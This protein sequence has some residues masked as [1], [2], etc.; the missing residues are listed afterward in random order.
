MMGLRTDLELPMI[1]SSQP[2]KLSGRDADARS[3]P[4]PSDLSGAQFGGEM[5]K[6]MPVAARL[7]KVEQE[8]VPRLAMVLRELDA[9]ACMFIAGSTKQSDAHPSPI[10]DLDVIIIAPN[11]MESDR[12]FAFLGQAR[13]EVA[14]FFQVSGVCP[15][16][17]TRNDLKISNKR[18]TVAALDGNAH[19][20][21]AFVHLLLYRGYEECHAD[22]AHRFDS[23]AKDAVCVLRPDLPEKPLHDLSWQELE[24]HRNLL[25][26]PGTEEL[27]LQP[28]DSISRHANMRALSA[29]L[30][31][32]V[33]DFEI[34]SGGNVSLDDFKQYYQDVKQVVRYLAPEFAELSCALESLKAVMPG[35]KVQFETA[36][37][38]AG[39]YSKDTR[40]K[41]VMLDCAKSLLAYIDQQV[42]PLAMPASRNTFNPQQTARC[43]NEQDRWEQIAL[44]SNG[45]TQS[46]L[47]RLLESQSAYVR[48]RAVEHLS[49]DGRT[50]A[51]TPICKAL[52]DSDL[53]VR[54]W[55]AH[56]LSR[57]GGDAAEAQTG[58]KD[59]L[60][61]RSIAARYW[62]ASALVALGELM[63]VRQAIVD[64]IFSPLDGG[65]SAFRMILDSS[66]HSQSAAYQLAKFVW[67]RWP[68]KIS[69]EDI[70]RCLASVK[71]K[72]GIS[73]VEMIKAIKLL[74]RPSHPIFVKALVDSGPGCV[75]AILKAFESCDGPTARALSDVLNEMGD[76][77][78]VSEAILSALHTVA[79][80]NIPYLIVAFCGH[81]KAA[82]EN[83]SELVEWFVA[84]HRPDIRRGI[85]EVLCKLGS[86]AYLAMPAAMECALKDPDR[87]S[88]LLAI[89]FVKALRKCPKPHVPK[90]YDAQLLDLGCDR[91][92]PKELRVE[93]ISD[94]DRL[95]IEPRLLLSTL[96]SAVEDPD[97]DV[98]AVVLSMLE[99]IGE[100]GSNIDEILDRALRRPEEE[101]RFKAIKL[102]NSFGGWDLKQQLFS[103]A[104][105]DDSPLVRICA[106]VA[107]ICNDDG[108]ASKP[109]EVV[110]NILRNH[111]PHSSPV[112]VA[113][114][115][116]IDSPPLYE[117]LLPNLKDMLKEQDVE[118]KVVALQALERL[119]DY[120]ESAYDEICN[121]E[122]HPD[123]N[124]R[125]AA[126][127][128]KK[129]ISPPED[130]GTFP[131]EAYEGT[132]DC[133]DDDGPR[134]A[135]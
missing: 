85:L 15:I 35:L 122:C 102:A 10:S 47:L 37:R 81:K 90:S 130:F 11:F 33:A 45:P 132:Q 3:I 80:K 22:L 115:G 125:S 59:L 128:A 126:A 49:D 99:R 27:R 38:A 78:G 39:G 69:K 135:R 2:D 87:E 127:D 86:D 53:G 116:I 26:T 4:H 67:Q 9:T 29:K 118:R 98:A 79:P 58:L 60:K 31:A 108:A 107:A 55:A 88:R 40:P 7:L 92:Q 100:S 113:L 101:S 46:E 76:Q 44:D 120:A 57:F 114:Q 104:I 94:L 48:R 30:V 21:E 16:V 32:A 51:I 83:I 68:D 36:Q 105:H 56:A 134:E 5:A 82:R 103:K 25:H 129:R 8:F 73:P 52:Q 96:R 84:E 131:S 24:L 43:V 6:I 71:R 75:S 13:Q 109:L 91:T 133:D 41:K 119:G 111:P 66:F 72:V 112:D 12:F 95:E 63:A 61:D 18:R 17:F 20:P 70:D 19:Y 42:D 64:K 106:A 77:K 110:W 65:R 54:C 50:S 34:Y 74:P 97:R 93:V 124:V 123:H 23:I 62:A 121:L 1:N 14:N 117:K 89:R 28:P